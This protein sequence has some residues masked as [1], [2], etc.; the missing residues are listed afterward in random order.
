MIRKKWFA[1]LLVAHFFAASTS[2]LAATKTVDLPAEDSPCK[3]LNISAA[4]SVPMLAQ[5]IVCDTQGQRLVVIGD[6][7]G[8]NEIPDFVS[9]I[10]QA[11]ATQRPVR[12]GLEIESFELKPIATYMGSK[13]T[14]ADRAALLHDDF[15]TAGQGRTSQ[16]IVRLIDAMRALKSSGRDVAV[17]TMVPQYPGDAIVKKV[18]GGGV[19]WNIKMAESIQHQLD[20]TKPDTL[21]IALMGNEHSKYIAANRG[22]DATVSERLAR[23]AP[24]IVDLHVHG[25]AWNCNATGCGTHTFGQADASAK[26]VRVINRSMI[27]GTLM[28]RLQA[29]LPVLTASPP[30]RKKEK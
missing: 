11:A 20:S 13:G 6:F 17:F 19:Y 3:G 4:A 24:Y 15:W 27:G 8:S 23:D 28:V 14:S 12:L 30:A 29:S 25:E 26:K 21:V 18:G 22:P 5:A 9:L 2:I 10:A 16:A 1:W 7:H